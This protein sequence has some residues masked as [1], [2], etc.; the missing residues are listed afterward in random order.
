MKPLFLILLIVAGSH[1]KDSNSQWEWFAAEPVDGGWWVVQGRALV[2]QA[3]TTFSAELSDR[4]DTGLV[5]FRMQG[6][7]TGVR[8][9]VSVTQLGTD[10]EPFTASGN[11]S[12]YCPGQ[13]YPGRKAIVLTG[14]G[15][16]I[17]GLFRDIDPC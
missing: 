10:A 9:S 8:V 4:E 1:A 17:I 16:Q 11:V 12:R 2:N 7:S 13:G 15:Q 3:G 6:T 5:R 14:S